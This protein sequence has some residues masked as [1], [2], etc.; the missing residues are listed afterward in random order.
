MVDDLVLLDTS[1]VI[2]IISQRKRLEDFLEFDY[3]ICLS[4]VA[5]GE[6]QYGVLNAGVSRLQEQAK[7]D[8]FLEG[9]RIL[10]V[11]INEA[12]A[13]AQIRHMLRTAGTPIPENDIWIA[14]TAI[15]WEMPL[16][17][18]DKHFARIPDL[19]LLP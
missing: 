8:A 6:L 17:T 10:P 5:I 13:Y 15:A 11:E 18:L 7:L 1:V 16:V 2:E 9:T 12:R 14:A 4:V 19:Q 3:S